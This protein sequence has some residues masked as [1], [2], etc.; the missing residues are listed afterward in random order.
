MRSTAI[1]KKTLRKHNL[2]DLYEPLHQHGI[3]NEIL[4]ELTQKD[5]REIAL[6][7]G[8]RIRYLKVKPGQEKPL[9]TTTPIDGKF[10]YLNS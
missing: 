1:L 7:V 2:S 9:E 5:M 6:S 10:S 4:W 3:T 8:Q